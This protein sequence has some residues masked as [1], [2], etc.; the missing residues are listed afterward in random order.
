MRRLYDIANVLASLDLLERSSC[1]ATFRP[2]YRWLRAPGGAAYPAP[3]PAVAG[4]LTWCARGRALGPL[5]VTR[6]IVLCRASHA[7]ARPARRAAPH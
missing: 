4:R 6:G 7:P 2:A 5:Y 3:A 1:P